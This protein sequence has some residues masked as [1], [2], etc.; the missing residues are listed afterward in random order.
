[1]IKRAVVEAGKSPCVNTGKVSVR[2]DKNGEALAA[3]QKSAAVKIPA[4][5]APADVDRP[6]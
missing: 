2:I 3:G 6:K 5:Q 1:M 4:S